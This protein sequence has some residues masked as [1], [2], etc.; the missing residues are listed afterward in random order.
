MLELML[1]GRK[2]LSS[3]EVYNNFINKIKGFP[4]K[5]GNDSPYTTDGYCTTTMITP[6]GTMW[7]TPWGDRVTY[8]SRLSRIAQHC[9]P[10]TMLVDEAVK[11]GRM[12][13]FKFQYIGNKITYNSYTKNGYTSVSYGS[14][15]GLFVIDFLY[16]DINNNKVMRINPKIKTVAVAW[17]G[18]FI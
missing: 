4:S 6:D 5:T 1:G 10:N 14:F 17:D 18:T 16:F 11:N 3:S 9:F 8:D 13:A 12:V 7:G 15:N 2:N